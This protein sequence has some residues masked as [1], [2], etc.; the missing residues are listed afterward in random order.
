MQHYYNY[1]SAQE[2][3]DEAHNAYYEV[4]GDYYHP[5]YDILKNTW[6]FE[7]ITASKL[8]ADF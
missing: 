2:R 5:R 4:I 1:S 8:R 6:E 7:K 3:A